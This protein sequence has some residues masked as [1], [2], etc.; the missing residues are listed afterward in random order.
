[1]GIFKKVNQYCREGEYILPIELYAIFEGSTSKFWDTH[2][3]FEKTSKSTPKTLTKAFMNLL[4]INTIVPI[5]F[6]YNKFNRQSSH[7]DVIAI[8]QNIP[9][10]HNSTVDKFHT[11]YTFG[12]TALES[13]ALIQLKQNYCSKN[14]CLQCAIGSALLNRN[15]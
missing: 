7:E 5:K 11:L 13:Q 15:S 1:M 8:M 14:K 3:T 2:Y 6:A 9:M 10:E 12:K 4:I